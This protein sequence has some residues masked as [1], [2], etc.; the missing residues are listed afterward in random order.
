M[1]RGFGRG[2]GRYGNALPFNRRMISMPYR[3]RYSPWS[4]V[5]IILLIAMA[6]IVISLFF[7]AAFYIIAL[8]ILVAVREGIRYYRYGRWRW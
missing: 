4:I 3:W 5:D 1:P 6:Y 7:I 2:Y 8:V